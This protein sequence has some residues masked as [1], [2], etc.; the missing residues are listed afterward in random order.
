[1]VPYDHP[2]RIST[3]SPPPSPVRTRVGSCRVSKVAPP[4][5]GQCNRLHAEPSLTTITE[6]GNSWHSTHEIV[7]QPELVVETTTY[8]PTQKTA[9]ESCP[10]SQTSTPPSS[11]Q[12]HVTTK[13]TATAHVKVEVHTPLP[14]AVDREVGGGNSKSRSSRSSRDSGSESDHSG[15]HSS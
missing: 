2:D 14:G 4:R 8:G 13:V 1:V 11:T 10:S 5:R 6:E 9:S 7:V 3:P 12:S 15:R